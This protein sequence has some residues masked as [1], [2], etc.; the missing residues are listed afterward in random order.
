[1]AAS[2]GAWVTL[3]K[4]TLHAFKNTGP[5]PA[6]LLILVHPSGLEKFFAEVGREATGPS[7]DAPAVTPA[8]IEKLLAIS[9]KYE[10]EIQ[11]PPQ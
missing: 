1:M 4:G 9:P 5:T 10:I 6:K 8:D 7:T 11:L 2:A 3:P